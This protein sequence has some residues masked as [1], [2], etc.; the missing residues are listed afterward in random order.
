VTKLF[1]QADVDGDGKLET[2]ELRS[3]A[4]KALLR[5]IR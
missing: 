2:K 4:G 1:K 3:K 5:L